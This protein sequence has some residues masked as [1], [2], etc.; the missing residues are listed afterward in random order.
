MRLRGAY[1]VTATGLEKDAD[2]NVVELRCTLDRAIW[3]ALAATVVEPS[4]KS[5]FS[6]GLLVLVILLRPQG[7]FGKSVI[8]KV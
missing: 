5:L 8:K 1:L 7:L 2:G 6:Y 4:M 3:S